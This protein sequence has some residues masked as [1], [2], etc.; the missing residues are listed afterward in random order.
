MAATAK[1]DC[2]LCVIVV[3]VV[4]GGPITVI[5]SFGSCGVLVGLAEK[6]WSAMVEGGAAVAPTN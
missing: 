1:E 5:G 3:V 4:C 6:K 2:E